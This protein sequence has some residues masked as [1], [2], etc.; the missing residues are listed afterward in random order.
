MTTRN[1]SATVLI[2][3]RE[4]AV[5]APG[6]KQIKRKDRVDLYWAKDETPLLADYSP[7][8]VRIHVDLSDTSAIQK[9]E[10][11]CRREQDAMLRWLEE[12]TSGDKERLK[13]KFNGTFGSI[14]NLYESDE[15]SGYADLQSLPVHSAH[16]GQEL[17]VYYR[18]HPYFGRKVL[19]RR[20]AQ[21][22]TGQFLSVQGPA[23]IV[24]LIAGWMLDP[25]I[26][27][28]MTIG[29]P[30]VDLA[31]LVELKRL[32]IGLATPAHSQSDVGI[33]REESNEVSQIAGAGAEPANETP[34]RQK[35][36]RWG[37][38]RRAERDHL[39]AGSN[40]HAGGRPAGRGA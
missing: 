9:I 4:V 13:P 12:G 3:G 37:G 7:A 8:T 33:V 19:V 6:L 15:E 23:G 18:Y 11:I 27:A 32:L 40:S 24:V 1:R 16:V 17:E 36:A 21:R 39:G 34:I 35:P 25:V 30:R 31:T 22:A 38:T 26:C 29:A 5:S 20:I 14:C 10:D 28:G 2:A